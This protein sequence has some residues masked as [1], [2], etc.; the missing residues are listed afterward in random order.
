MRRFAAENVV[1]TA[2][3]HSAQAQRNDS[4][5]RAAAAAG[6]KAPTAGSKAATAGSKAATA[7]AAAVCAE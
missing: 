4:I 5:Q 3:R 6:S 1:G 7:A 2:L